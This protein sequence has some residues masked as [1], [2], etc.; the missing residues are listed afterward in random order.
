MSEI[1]LT[2]ATGAEIGRIVDEVTP[3]LGKEDPIHVLMACLSL[4]IVVQDPEITPED[5]ARGVKETSEFIACFLSCL[6]TPANETIN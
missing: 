1:S 5:L 4:A 6:Y 2:R 3:I